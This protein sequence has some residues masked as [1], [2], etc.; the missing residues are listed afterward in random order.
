MRWNYTVNDI[1]RQHWNTIQSLGLNRY[2]LRHLHNISKCHT[3]E[4]GGVVL[5]CTDCG[6]VQYKYHS[7]RNRHC[8]SCQG[9]KREE[10]IAKQQQYLLNVP[11]FH[12]VFT[13]PSELHQLCLHKPKVMY[14]ILFDA[15]YSTIKTL[16]KVK[17]YLGAQTGMTAVLHTW[18]QNLSLHPH[19]HCIVPGGG[20]TKSGQWKATRNNGKY[21][22]P[23]KVMARIYRAIFIK[24]LK[25]LAKQGVISL[26]KSLRE[27]LYNKRWVVYAKRPFTNPNHVIEY[28]GRYTHKVAISNYRL[29]KVSKTHVTFKWKDYRHGNTKKEMT[30]SI[31]K[32][33]RRFA[34]HILPH[35][36]VRIRHYGIL[37]NHG[38]K[39]TIPTLQQQQNYEPQIS[40]I[41]QR[42][43]TGVETCNL[44]QCNRLITTIL[45][46]ANT[47]SP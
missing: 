28:L 22:F 6:H 39:T 32:F 7:C 31:S 27:K 3:A 30:L 9:S 33:L 2:Q 4:L 37:S 12:V 19:L 17:K 10:W 34:L 43:I 23:A 1:I 38:R 15:S 41:V 36:F 35:R 44:C 5:T 42:P 45:T 13:L 24:Q 18:S 25:Q 8:P 26:S 46:R 40:L 11:Y 20:V 29:I 47:R 16:A 14:K 21:L